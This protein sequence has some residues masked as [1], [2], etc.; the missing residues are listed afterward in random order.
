MIASLAAY[1]AYHRTQY[2]RELAILQKILKTETPGMQWNGPIEHRA[3]WQ[4]GGPGWLRAFLGDDQMRI[5]DRVV[6]I[7]IAPEQIKDAAR[8]PNVMAIRVLGGVEDKQLKPLEERPSLEALD[9]SYGL[10]STDENGFVEECCVRLPRLSRLR[11][12]N[13]W[14]ATF[15]GEG[16]EHMPRLEHLDLT[17][18]LMDD[19][20]APVLARLSKLKVLSLGRTKITGASLQHLTKLTEL[21]ELNLNGTD[22]SDESLRHLFGLR[23]LRE[24]LLHDTEVTSRGVAE[25]QKALPNCEIYWEP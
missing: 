5:F 12:L 23:K 15:R 13:V 21:Q 11:G 4:H 20:Y 17:E 24:I 7:D 1:L 14:E 10:Y 6:G 9:L 8:L 2:R 22:V 18:T 16:L 25:L 19:E 3:E